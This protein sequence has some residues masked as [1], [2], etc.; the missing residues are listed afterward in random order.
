MI[1]AVVDAV[2]VVVV[3]VVAVVVLGLFLLLLLVCQ[4]C[5]MFAHG[6]F[7][8]V[9]DVLDARMIAPLNVSVVFGV[10]AVLFVCLAVL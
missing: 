8:I 5:G 3:V 7:V 4:S 1:I 6:V 9:D 10:C 2:F